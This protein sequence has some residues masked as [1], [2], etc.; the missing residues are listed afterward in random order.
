[1]RTV[2]MS[3]LAVL[4]LIALAAAIAVE[5]PGVT[6]VAPAP[7]I[8]ISPAFLRLELPLGAERR[9]SI[10]LSSPSDT[11][12][13]NVGVDCAC[14]HADVPL[15]LALPAGRAV[16][17][18]FIVR[19]T[20]PGV[21]S[22]RFDTALGPAHTAIQVVLP[23]LGEGRAQLDAAISQAKQHAGAALWFVV[24]DLGDNVRNC[25]CS[26]GSLGGGDHLAALPE[27]VRSQ[28]PGQAVRFLLSGTTDP[29][30]FD[31]LRA[32]GWERDEHAIA[33][34]AAPE[35]AITGDATIVIPTTP[36]RVRHAKLLTPALPGGLG[37]EAVVI[38]NGFPLA[39]V[40]IPND[41]T[42]PG[43]AAML[44]RFAAPAVRVDATANPSAN[45]TACHQ[46]AHTTWLATK[47][48]RAWASLAAADQTT[49]CA[50]C[51]S[52]PRAGALPAP[53]VHCQS[54]HAGS[55]AHAAAP[56][57]KPPPAVD[58]RICHDAKHHPGFDREAGWKAIEHR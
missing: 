8:T 33:V 57:S 48:A 17:V 5:A 50:G 24:H 39:R 26:N 23:G 9:I 41:R 53:N 10:S 16:A 7:S 2:H 56:A 52:T 54:C 14:L 45:C 58:C 49:D 4:A 29:E 27:L 35:S 6:P 20:I 44:A 11:T 13:S 37:I 32:R 1:M 55:D 28:A 34:S 30:L 46:A 47:H 43:D 38:A 51:H 18:P 40:T 19:G 22:I 15:P 31:A 3:P 21:K 12:L 36:T 25:G 42:L